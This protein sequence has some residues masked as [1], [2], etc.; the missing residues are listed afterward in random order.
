M[1]LLLRS[2]LWSLRTLIFNLTI[3]F[4]K[5]DNKHFE[6]WDLTG[7][8]YSSYQ[9]LIFFM[10]KYQSVQ[11]KLLLRGIKF[12][13]NVPK[14]KIV[15]FWSEVAKTR[16]EV[17]FLVLKLENDYCI[18]VCYIDD[19]YQN[20]SYLLYVDKKN[21]TSVMIFMQFWVICVNLSVFY[22]Q[23]FLCLAVQQRV[24]WYSLWNSG[25]VYFYFAFQLEIWTLVNYPH[26]FDI[27]WDLDF[28]EIS[29]L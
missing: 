7:P 15:M 14:V 1:Y 26:L 23:F 21:Y 25:F 18:A 24:L 28:K 2:C 20:P 5:Q 12:G 22:Y 8:L 29:E 3:L 19:I 9:T 6:M 27:C 16:R 13:G 17:A 10:K 4:I 11:G